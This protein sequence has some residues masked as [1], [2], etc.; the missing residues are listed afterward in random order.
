MCVSQSCYALFSVAIEMILLIAA[1]SMAINMEHAP[2]YVSLQIAALSTFLTRLAHPPQGVPLGSIEK[3]HA[4][5]F[6]ENSAANFAL[7]T[8][9][10]FSYHS[11]TRGTCAFLELNKSGC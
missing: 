10:L 9:V 1:L 3:G 5:E 7:H 6:C 11:L 8:S 4:N 2:H